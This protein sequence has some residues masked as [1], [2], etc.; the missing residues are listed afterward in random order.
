MTIIT[1]SHSVHRKAGSGAAEIP[2]ARFS[3]SEE[4]ANYLH[5]HPVHRGGAAKGVFRF[6]SL[7]HGGVKFKN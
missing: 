5:S 1:L 6:F 3:I 4:G 2:G 7:L